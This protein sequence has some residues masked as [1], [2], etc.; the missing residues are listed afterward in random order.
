[1]RNTVAR[2]R[3]ARRE[4]ADLQCLWAPVS[5]R[6]RVAD[7][8]RV[9][10]LA[11]KPRHT[12]SLARNSV[13]QIDVLKAWASSRFCSISTRALRSSRPWHLHLQL[14]QLF[15]SSSFNNS[16]PL[17]EQSSS[18]PL[19]SLATGR[20]SSQATSILHLQPYGIDIN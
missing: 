1:M 11:Q 6:G 16:S 15:F 19:T 3:G 18:P 4:S 20:P 17:L 9:T 12:K 7:S 8:G 13:C 14:L 2:N 10:P 5:G